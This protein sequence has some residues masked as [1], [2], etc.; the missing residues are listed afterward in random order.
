MHFLKVNEELTNALIVQFTATQY[1]LTRVGGVPIHL[2][3]NALF[4]FP[5]ALK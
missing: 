3:I 2:M 1:A 5:L 4:G